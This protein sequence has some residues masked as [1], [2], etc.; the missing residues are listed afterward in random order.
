VIEDRT[1]IEF[2]RFSDAAEISVMSKNDIEY[3]LGW[4]YTLKRIAKL[5][6]DSSRN[7]VVARVGS[8]LAGFGIMTYYEDQ[9]NLD[10]LAVTRSFRRMRIGTQIVEW[11][12][13]VALTA[14]AFNIFV[15]VRARNTSAIQFYQSVGFSVLD[16][17]KAYCRGVEAGLIMAKS[18]RRMFNAT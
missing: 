10:L 12:E 2:A 8:H 11:L 7:V 16:D 4:K 6:G 1:L 13:K 9:A 14:G 3:G 5:I 18:L 15:Q 17:E